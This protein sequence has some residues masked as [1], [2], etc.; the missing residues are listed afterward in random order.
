LYLKTRNGG[1][2]M[3]KPLLPLLIALVAG[4]SC[5]HFMSLPDLP[6]QIFLVG[7]LLLLLPAS[8]NQWRRIFPLAL[9]LCF[10]LVGILLMGLYFLP[11]VEKVTITNYIGEEKTTAEGMVC[12]NPQVSPDRTELIIC[13]VRV[14]TRGAPLPVAGHVL[15]HLREYASFQ[16]GD[17]VRFRV[18]LRLPRNFG[19]P[20]AFDYES[21]LRFRGILARGFIND[22][23]GIIVIRSLTA[24]PWLASLEDFRRRIAKAIEHRAPETEGTIIKAMILGDQREIPQEVMEKFNRTGTTHIIAISG[25]NVG[26]VALFSLWLI[27]PLLKSSQWILLRGN[28]TA[29]STSFAILI[30]VGYTFIAG[31]GLSVVRASLMVVAFM[32]S[33]LLNRDRDLTNTLALAALLI[34]I[35]SPSSL[36]SISFQL[37]FSAVAAILFMAP[38]LTALLGPPPKT[39]DNAQ[40]NR[41]RFT[42]LMHKG[43]HATAVFFFVSLAATLGTLPLILFYFNRLSLVTLAANLMVVP[44]LGVLATPL[45]LFIILAVPL[46]PLLADGLIGTSA[47]LVRISLTLIDTFSG[48]SWAALFVST[49]TLPEIVAYY[50]L[51]VSSVFLI[52]RRLSRTHPPTEQKRGF[53]WKSLSVLALL[54]FMI[55]GLYLYDRSCHRGRLSL[56]AVDVGQGSS[57]LVRFPGGHRMLVDGGGFYDETFDVGR[58]VLAPF[59]WKERITTIDTVV[60]THPHPDHL[61]GLLFILENFRV[62]EVWTN[63]EVMDSPLYDSFLR[64]IHERAIAWQVLSDHTPVRQLAGVEIRIMNPSAVPPSF[65]KIAEQRDRSLD[66]E[67]PADP[68]L[69]SLNE[70]A[71]ERS[72]VMRLSFGRRS[73]LLP[74]DISEVAES[75]LIANGDALR[76]DVLF[77]PHHGSLRSGK[78]AF[79]EKVRPKTVIVSCGTDNLFGFPHPEVLRRYERIG[80]SLFRTDRDGAVTVMTDG[81]DLQFRSFRSKGL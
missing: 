41:Q 57:V 13:S 75:R 43:L 30:V 25:F 1:L 50:L 14:I 61:Q 66:R 42:A 8:R 59:L 32:I 54:F 10:F 4:I 46:F 71:N 36:F 79:L 39:T 34:L 48:W 69:V 68:P 7:V 60:L 29:L 18:R 44:I 40:T 73:F 55:D 9:L 15:L 23:S 11:P 62:R 21:V 64:I 65:P 45:C 6:V 22:A 5:R 19:N 80:A 35:I 49:P 24:N 56:T 72:L 27:R 3:S 33:L 74:G 76:S 28:V 78:S 70:D 38:R 2:T 17:W 67:R 12:E 16:L 81:S 51:L 63:G 53:L 26:I 37:S 58:Y 52:E 31:A 47:W 77:A 20:G